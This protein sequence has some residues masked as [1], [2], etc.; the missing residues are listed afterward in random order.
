MNA[1]TM[2]L[3]RQALAWLLALGSIGPLLGPPPARASNVCQ[4][5]PIGKDPAVIKF[6]T[7][8][9]HLMV[10]GRIMPHDG[11]DPTTAPITITL[12]KFS[13]AVIYEATLP[14]GAVAQKGANTWLFSDKAAEAAEASV[15]ELGFKYRSKGDY[16]EFEV[17]TFGDLSSA[18]SPDMTFTITVGAQCFSQVD[19]WEET[20]N[21]WRADFPKP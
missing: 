21:G 4:C 12:E 16:F 15:Y 6:G 17:K 8:S 7:T 9:D 3:K 11:F 5:D 20:R 19:L 18:D 14:A 10:H 2:T 1:T 13:G